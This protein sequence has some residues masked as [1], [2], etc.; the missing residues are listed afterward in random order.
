MRAGP[1]IRIS[2]G[3]WAGVPQREARVGHVPSSQPT[4]ASTPHARPPSGGRRRASRPVT[5]TVLERVSVDSVELELERPVDAESLI[6]EDAFG[7][8]EFLPYWAEQWPSGVALA[9]HVAGW[10]L[11][12]RTVVELGCGLGLPSLVAARLGAVVISTDWSSDALELLARNAARNGVALS[13]L[14]ADWRQPGAFAGLGFVDAV[15]GADLLYEERNIAPVVACLR[16]FSAP[17]MVADPGRRHA[18]PFLDTIRAHD[19]T[20]DTA[21]DPRLLRGG[22]HQLQ[23]PVRPS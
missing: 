10:P 22:I 21:L 14:R 20:V 17:A 13:T 16:M 6:D 1:A 2:S 9:H 4:T 12:G 23:P 7:D 3:W 19:W 8:D 18:E 11:E 5:E 15:L